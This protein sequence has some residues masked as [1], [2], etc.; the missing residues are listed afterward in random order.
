MFLKTCIIFSEYVIERYKIMLIDIGQQHGRLYCLD[1]RNDSVNY[2]RGFIAIKDFL[3]IPDY[4][5]GY[6]YAGP[7][8]FT[9]R[10]VN[11]G[12]YQVFITHNGRGKFI[13]DHEEFYAESDT[14]AI[15]DLSIPHTYQTAGNF[16]EYEWVNFSGPS[17]AY[18]YSK[19]N[20]NGFAI[21][22]LADNTILKTLM[23]QIR[24]LVIGIDEQKYVQT[25][26]TILCMLDAFYD[27]A[28]NRSQQQ[29]L[30]TCQDNIQRVMRFIDE[31]YMENI[32][33]NQLSELA[34]LSKYY[35]IRVFTQYTGMTPF[36][37]LTTI[38]LS[39]ARQKLVLSHLS[40]EE[41]SRSVGFGNSKNLIRSF[42]QATGKTP[43]KYRKEMRQKI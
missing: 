35:F 28:F 24:K 16:W 11:C 27:F 30:L 21:Y 29:Q 13:I 19:I 9:R 4:N 32:S 3:P 18:Y 6:Y 36:K 2:I 14:I 34:Y 12:L 41:I 39:H 23:S 33:L 26:T 10:N 20:P 25:G 37:Y 42:K 17:C 15:L 7:R 22:N 5:Y 1:L 38:R 8:H 40:I 31:H 43:E